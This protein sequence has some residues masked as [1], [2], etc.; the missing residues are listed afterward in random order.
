MPVESKSNREH[1]LFHSNAA[2]EIISTFN[3]WSLLLN[4][5]K[6]ANFN[7][8]LPDGEMRCCPA[9]DYMNIPVGFATAAGVAAG[10]GTSVMKVNKNLKIVHVQMI[11]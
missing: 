1:A 5:S 4:I 11:K 2:W 9:Y 6:W 3:F 7:S 10:I 8:G